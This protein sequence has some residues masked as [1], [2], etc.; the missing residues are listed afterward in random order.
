MNAWTLVGLPRENATAITLDNG[1]LRRSF[2]LL[3]TQL[4]VVA[5]F[6]Q[7]VTHV[8]KNP[9]DRVAADTHAQTVKQY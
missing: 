9:L 1:E 7:F 6:N 4:V 5:Q 3:F 8:S 2:D